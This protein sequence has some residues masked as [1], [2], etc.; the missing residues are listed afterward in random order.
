MARYFINIGI[1]ELAFFGTK[2]KM[3]TYYG[4]IDSSHKID[5]GRDSKGNKGTFGNLT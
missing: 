3:F 4:N 2:P 1:N 5:L